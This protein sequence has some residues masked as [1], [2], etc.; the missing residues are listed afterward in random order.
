ME[1]TVNS[2]GCVRF[3]CNIRKI[4]VYAFMRYAPSERIDASLFRLFHAMVVCAVAL[5]TLQSFVMTNLKCNNAKQTET[6][7][8]VGVDGGQWTCCVM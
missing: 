5:H 6:R 2:I 8:V 7:C 1:H 4:N 3:A